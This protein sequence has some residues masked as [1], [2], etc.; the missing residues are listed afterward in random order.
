MIKQIGRD[1]ILYDL[2]NRSLHVLNMTAAKV[3]QLC[4]GSHTPEEMAK[5]LV[6]SFHGVEYDEARKDVKRTLHIFEAKCLVARKR[7]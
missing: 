4:D 7:E 6:E 5:M 3:F 2:T 1:L